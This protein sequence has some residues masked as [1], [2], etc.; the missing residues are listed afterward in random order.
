MLLVHSPSIV[1]KDLKPFFSVCSFLLANFISS[2]FTIFP[3][4]ASGKDFCEEE[5]NPLI[6]VFISGLIV[7]NAEILLIYIILV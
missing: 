4:N 6:P 2:V 3:V 7:I 1:H 5:K